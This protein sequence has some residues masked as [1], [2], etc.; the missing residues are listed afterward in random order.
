[1]VEETVERRRQLSEKPQLSEKQQFSEKGTEHRCSFQAGQ[2]D[3][4]F[5]LN[6]R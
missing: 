5:R 2:T 3:R 6:A 1:M 4:R